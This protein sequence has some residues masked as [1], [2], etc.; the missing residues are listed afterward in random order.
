[1]PNNSGCAVIKKNIVDDMS[2]VLCDEKHEG[3]SVF[4]RASIADGCLKVSG[5]DYG[6]AVDDIMGD[7]DYE[8]FYDF[9]Q[10]NTKKLID[11]LTESKTPIES[12]FVSRFG[13]MS[14]CKALREF[15]EANGVTHEFFAY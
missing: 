12:V 2:I 4:V 6:K 11:L 14:G 5:Q 1:M 3:I 10:G 8:Y 13:G 15:C 7:T 9:D